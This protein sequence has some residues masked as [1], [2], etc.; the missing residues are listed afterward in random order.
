VGR[1]S[2]FRP[3]KKL[4][5]SRDQLHFFSSP[6]FEEDSSGRRFPSFFL[7]SS[8]R[9]CCGSV[10]ANVLPF[11]TLVVPSSRRNSSPPSL[12]CVRAATLCSLCPP[13]L[14]SLSFPSLAP[15]SILPFSPAAKPMNSFFPLSPS[16]GDSIPRAGPNGKKQTPSPSPLPLHPTHNVQFNK[17]IFGLQFS[18]RARRSRNRT[19]LPLRSSQTSQETPHSRAGKYSS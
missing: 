17:R 4:R 14:L 3:R 2:Y 8:R 11:V 9:C 19:L 10:H 5:F 6:V 13:F 1:F 16:L 12:R 15:C 7:S 18:L